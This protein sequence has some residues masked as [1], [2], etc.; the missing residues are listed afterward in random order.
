MQSTIK[1]PMHS[2]KISTHLWFKKGGGHEFQ[3]HNNENM[4]VALNANIN[5][6]IN[7]D[8]GVNINTYANVNAKINLNVKANV[9]LNQ[10]SSQPQ[11]A[12]RGR[13]STQQ[14]MARCWKT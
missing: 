8:V 11:R 2:K 14:W 1:D 5:V 13:S 4:S 9:D 10:S 3:T 6:N 7:I 12:V